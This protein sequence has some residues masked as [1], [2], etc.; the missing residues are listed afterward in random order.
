MLIFKVSTLSLSLSL[1]LRRCTGP[2]FNDELRITINKYWP[3]VGE[4]PFCVRSQRHSGTAWLHG[5]YLNWF[6]QQSSKKTHFN[7]GC[8]HNLKGN[9][10]YSLSL[11]I[12]LN[13]SSFFDGIYDSMI[14]MILFIMG[15]TLNILSLSLSVSLCLSLLVALHVALLLGWS[16]RASF[17]RDDP[18][19]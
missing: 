8:R 15:I 13:D 18:V 16:C 7:K 2:L 19:H 6:K 3:A 14:I 11:I 1:F 10:V 4:W 12:N 9:K 5:S 17:G